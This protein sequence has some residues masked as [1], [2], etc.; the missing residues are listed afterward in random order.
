MNNTAHN[1]G[2]VRWESRSASFINF[3]FLHIIAA[4]WTAHPRRKIR[5]AEREGIITGQKNFCDSA[6]S[7]HDCELECFCLKFLH[8]GKGRRF[9]CYCGSTAVSFHFTL[10]FS[11]DPSRCTS[12]KTILQFSH[13]G[14]NP[15]TQA[16]EHTFPLGG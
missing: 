3:F 1:N 15:K 6:R 12:T 7:P 5:V 16:E 10:H 11:T 13:S 2:K 8:K 9:C 14:R 4:A